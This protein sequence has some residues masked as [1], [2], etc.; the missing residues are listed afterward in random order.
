VVAKNIV[1]SRREEAKSIMVG[2]Y[3]LKILHYFKIMWLIIRL[4]IL[5]AHHL[6]LGLRV[7]HL[8]GLSRGCDHIKYNESALFL[9]CYS[10][11]A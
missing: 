11:S 7:M 10:A 2:S 5:C 3:T 8:V 1:L 4:K 6:Y 9:S